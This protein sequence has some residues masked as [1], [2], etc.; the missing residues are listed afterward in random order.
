MPLAASLVGLGQ[1][2]FLLVLPLLRLAGLVPMAAC[3]QTGFSLP[4]NQRA[5]TTVGFC[6]GKFWDCPWLCGEEE[7]NPVAVSAMHRAEG[8][9]YKRPQWSVPAGLVDGGLIG[10]S[11]LQTRNCFHWMSFCWQR[12]VQ[13]GSR[14]QRSSL[15]LGGS[16]GSMWPP[17][18]PDHPPNP[19]C[20]FRSCSCSPKATGSARRS[21]RP[22]IRHPLA[23]TPCC[24]SPCASG[25]VAQIWW[26]KCALGS[27]SWWTWQ[28]Q[29]GHRRFSDVPPTPPTSPQLLT[30]GL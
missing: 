18:G 15:G 11:V 27:S 14:D 26:R 16:G 28:A 17:M 1:G 13:E 10:H 23:P 22:P 4:A 8:G 6:G 30:C 20:V 3:A 5:H 24:R 9:W 25:A 29:S 12:A 7:G 21:P 19:T 2:A